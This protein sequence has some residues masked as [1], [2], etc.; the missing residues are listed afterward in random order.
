[1]SGDLVWWTGREGKGKRRRFF[2]SAGR[3]LGWSE[4]S[5]DRGMKK[6]ECYCE[7]NDTTRRLLATQPRAELSL[8]H[9]L[10]PVYV[11]S[12]LLRYGVDDKATS[13]A[14]TKKP[15]PGLRLTAPLSW[16][17]AVVSMS[18]GEGVYVRAYV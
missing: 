6:G 14:R 2:P 3:G 8:E 9:R 13:E 15:L 17:N 1:M 16:A 7:C 12:T 10:G 18:S 11:L 5:V 4:F